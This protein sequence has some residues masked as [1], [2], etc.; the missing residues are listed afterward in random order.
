M[1]GKIALV[2]G[3]NTGIGFAVAKDLAA[4]GMTVYLGSRDP[5]K[6]IA[7]AAEAKDYGDIRPVELDTTKE[8]TLRAAVQTIEAAHGRLDVL[9]NNAG[10][11]ID[12]ADAVSADPEI[13]R[14]SMETNAHGP[15][16]LTQL[17][18]PLLR[19]A[20]GARVVF[21]SS[22]AGCLTDLANPNGQMSQ[23]MMPYAYCL[24]KVALN[25]V[26]VL[27]AAAFRA[28][29]IKVNAASPGY[30]YSALSRFNGTRTPEQGAAII[31]HLATLGDDG[32]TAG[33]F[34]DDG[35]VPW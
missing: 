11:A 9:V 28:D 13:I 1:V 30:V 10:V 15:A 18:A 33:F 34:D 23:F 31:V 17:A 35:P 29:G 24:S 27:F 8:D 3:A 5:A 19:T 16:R 14:L 12:G 20:G 6:G 32:P 25:G 21:V 22:G 4:K 26:T 2:T 7:A